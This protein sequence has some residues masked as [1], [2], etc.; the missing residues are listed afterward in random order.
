[1]Q[2]KQRTTGNMK[3]IEKLDEQENENNYLSQT[4]K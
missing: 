1:M 2:L 3:S 4:Q